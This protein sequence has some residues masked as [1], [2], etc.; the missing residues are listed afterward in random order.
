MAAD[1]G[2]EVS[3]R[4]SRLDLELLRDVVREALGQ[5]GLELGRLKVIARALVRLGE[6]AL[7]LA[8]VEGERGRTAAAE[9]CDQGDAGGE[10]NTGRA[11]SSHA[12]TAWTPDLAATQTY[13]A[14]AAGSKREPRSGWRRAGLLQSLDG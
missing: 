12:T 3:L 13:P 11:E 10:A 9:H 8:G 2:R 7:L 5:G 6:V 4:V 14:G 1:V